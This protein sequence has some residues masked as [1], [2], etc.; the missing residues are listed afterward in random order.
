MKVE[1]E[2]VMLNRTNEAEGVINDSVFRMLFSSKN[3]K[4]TLKRRPKKKKT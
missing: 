1:K 4:V 3:W 2:D